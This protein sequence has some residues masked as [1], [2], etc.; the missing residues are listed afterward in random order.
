MAR[1]RNAK[2]DAAAAR[3]AID[4]ETIMKFEDRSC[5]N[6]D[7]GRVGGSA[8]NEAEGRT[9][10]R[11]GRNQL[12]GGASDEAPADAGSEREG[13]AL[14]ASDRVGATVA[15]AE[16]GVEE[17]GGPAGGEVSG[18][19]PRVGADVRDA[20]KAR[21]VIVAAMQRIV[22]EANGKPRSFGSFIEELKNETGLCPLKAKLEAVLQ[23]YGMDLGMWE[24]LHGMRQELNK[25]ADPRETSPGVRE[26]VKRYSETRQQ[27]WGALDT[28]MN[29]IGI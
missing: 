21:S 22:N 8:L 11:D 24:K 10:Q 4:S 26:A 14:L 27:A 17:V 23:I 12:G 28:A 13:D 29:L 5:S 2:Q 1:A 18:E 25:E 16:G 15:E 20:L 7:Y 9:A 19:V 3:E 6:I